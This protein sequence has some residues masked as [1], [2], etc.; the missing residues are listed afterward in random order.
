MIDYC[1]WKLGYRSEGMIMNAI[2]LVTKLTGNLLGSIQGVLLA[3]IGFD[4]KKNYLQQSDNTKFG[5]FALAYL[6]PMLTGSFSI[7]PKLMYK[8]TQQEKDDMYAQLR[9]RR[10]E[11]GEKA[12]SAAGGKD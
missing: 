11:E 3:R 6:F 9:I 5:I 10:A 12:N 2:G 1:E 4:M 8:I 7:I